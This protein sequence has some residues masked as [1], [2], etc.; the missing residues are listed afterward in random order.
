M[1]NACHG[2]KVVHLFFSEITSHVENHIKIVK[3]AQMLKCQF[4]RLQ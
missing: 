1:S 4:V 3:G 2:L